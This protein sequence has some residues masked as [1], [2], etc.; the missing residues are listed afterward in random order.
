LQTVDNVREVVDNL[1]SLVENVELKMK[2]SEE[3][4]EE[5]DG[6]E[7]SPENERFLID[8]K[9]WGVTDAKKDR[10]RRIVRI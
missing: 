3:G 7:T 8:A 4:N 5:I 9:P 1:P 6:D 10:L 2:N